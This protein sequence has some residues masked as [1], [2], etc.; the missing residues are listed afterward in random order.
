MAD[1]ITGTLQLQPSAAVPL[2]QQPAHQKTPSTAP[3]AECLLAA[4]C[5]AQLG[6]YLLQEQIG[7]GGAGTVYKAIHTALQR[8]VALKV[9]AEQPDDPILISRFRREMRIVGQLNHPNIVRPTDAGRINGIHYLAMDFIE[10]IDLYRLV[11]T[12]GQ[13]PIPDACELARQAALGLQHAH[14]H[15]LVHRDVK[16]PNLMLDRSG[17]VKILDLGIARCRTAHPDDEGLTI[18]GEVIGTVDYLAP[19]QAADAASADVRADIYGLGCT[20]YHLVAG[21]P[22]FSGPDY[23]SAPAKL[24]GHKMDP[25]PAIRSVRPEAPAAL[26]AVL[27]RMLAKDPA[28]RYATPAEAAAALEPLAQGRDLPGLLCAARVTPSLSGPQPRAEGPPVTPSRQWLAA[29]LVALG[30]VTGL[31][32][33]AWIFLGGGENPRLPEGDKT[34]QV[35]TVPALPVK[36]PPSAAAPRPTETKPPQPKQPPPETDKKPTKNP[37]ATAPASGPP[38]TKPLQPKQPPRGKDITP[39]KPPPPPPPPPPPEPPYK[40]TATNEY[41]WKKILADVRDQQDQSYYRRYFT[42]NHL[43]AAGASEQE[44]QWHRQAL[45]RAVKELCREREPLGPQAIDPPNNLVFAVD[46][47]RL[48]WHK[49]LFRRVEGGKERDR[50]SVKLFDLFLLEYPY[51]FVPQDSDTFDQLA[52]ELLVPAKQIRPIAVLRADWFVSA[53]TQPPLYE[54]LLQLKGGL[55]KPQGPDLSTLISPRFHDEPLGL[56][57][58]AAELGQAD[59]DRLAERFRTPAFSA[60]GLAPLADGGTVRRR[61][62]EACYPQVVR[63]LGLGVPV[64]PIDGLMHRDLHTGEPP[65]NVELKTDKANNVFEPEDQAAVS[66]VNRSDRALFI[67]LLRTSARGKKTLLTPRPVRLQAAETVRFPLEGQEINVSAG[68]GKEQ[69]T[70]FAADTEFPATELLHG[71]GMAD[72]VVHRS[73]TVPDRGGR[74]PVVGFNPTRFV[75]KTLEIEIR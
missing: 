18:H 27:E 22:P 32:A 66:V 34:A 13:L 49:Q 39:P 19:E 75:K 56:R 45:A 71:K 42:L 15:G 21:Q 1:E 58:V 7:K 30:V 60:L 36:T 70:L 24:L 46:L 10:G 59:P 16:P 41:V 20:L 17:T 29:A 25:A 12:L 6:P 8:V 67:E 61:A 48:G 52:R 11:D 62:W 72:R 63:A 50:S 40:G 23:E 73:D 74:R 31:S 2:T 69:V 54:D 5:P 43:A 65:L 64:V 47:R 53:A 37:S 33:A 35:P 4:A 28:H 38:E 68:L 14:E 3:G 26:E 55:G 9:L 57:A 51:A 44:L